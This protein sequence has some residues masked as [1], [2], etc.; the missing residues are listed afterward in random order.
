M[1]ISL[2]CSLLEQMGF[3]IGMEKPCGNRMLLCNV[4]CVILSAIA[5]AGK[6]V[7][8]SGKHPFQEADQVAAVKKHVEQAYPLYRKTE[9]NCGICDL[10]MIK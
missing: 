5:D 7:F 4:W 8:A 9:Y 3:P 10:N 6:S 2:S 1:V